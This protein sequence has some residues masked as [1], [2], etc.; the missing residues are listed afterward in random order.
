MHLKNIMAFHRKYSAAIKHTAKAKFP[1]DFRRSSEYNYI[2]N[3]NSGDKMKISLLFCSVLICMVFVSADNLAINGDLNTGKTLPD[4]WVVSYDTN[5]VRY[6]QEGGRN[7][8]PAVAITAPNDKA[9]LRQYE[10]QLVAGVRY[11]LSAWIRTENFS[12][13]Q[14]GSVAV[15]L[16]DYPW[17]A[18]DGFRIKDN[19]SDWTYYEKEIIAPS[20]ANGKYIILFYAGKMTGSVWIDD[21]NLE[22]LD[23]D[24]RTKSVNLI[25]A[26]IE[27]KKKQTYI[28]PQQSSDFTIEIKKEPGMDVVLEF[29]AMLAS[30]Y[31]SGY[32]NALEL[33]VNGNACSPE[34]VLGRPKKVNFVS[35]KGERS[36]LE[37]GCLLVFYSPEMD[38]AMPTNYAYYPVPAF[39]IYTY[40]IRVTALAENGR[41]IITVKNMLNPRYDFELVLDP[42][43]YTCVPKIKKT[44]AFMQNKNKTKIIDNTKVFSIAGKKTLSV[45]Y[46][47]FDFITDDYLGG[48]DS[49][50]NAEQIQFNNTNNGQILNVWSEKHPELTFRKEAALLKDG[51][52]LSLKAEWT[53]YTKAAESPREYSFRVPLVLLKGAKYKAAFGR[54]YSI[55]FTEGVISQ[56]MADGELANS[57]FRFINFKSDNVSLNMDFCPYGITHMWVDYPNA[58]EPT[59]C[60]IKKSG[61]Y[62]VFTPLYT[63]SWAGKSFLGEFHSAKLLIYEG[64]WDYH[65]KHSHKSWNYHSGPPAD[66]VYTF[67]TR[68]AGFYKK[69][70]L[71][72]Y[73]SEKGYG[74][75]STRGMALSSIHEKNIYSNAV[76][77]SAGN[78][79][80]FIIDIQ[81]GIY[82][83]TLNLGSPEKACGPFS[84]FIN[85]EKAADEIT[86]RAGEQKI[87]T[88]SRY[89]RKPDN[90]IVVRFT[91]K[92]WAVK[93][94]ARQIYIQQNEDYRIDRN[95]FVEEGIFNPDWG[96]RTKPQFNA[97]ALLS[98]P[99]YDSRKLDWRGDMKMTS[100]NS[101]AHSATEF[102]CNTPEQVERRVLELKKQGY[103][104]INYGV[105]FWNLAYRHRLSDAMLITRLITETAH[106]HNMKV[107]WHA[108]MPVIP[109]QGT[110]MQFMLSH[111]DWLKKDLRTGVPTLV[112]C[113]FNSGFRDDLRTML[114]TFTRETGVDGLMLDECY[115][116]DLDY[117]GCDNCRARFKRDTGL[118]MPYDNA[119]EIYGNENDSTWTA[120]T[121]WAQKS[122]G[123]WW[124]E[125]AGDLKKVN[126][127][128]VLMSYSVEHAE[129]NYARRVGSEMIEMARGANFIGTEQMPNNTIELY[130]YLYLF[131]K[132]NSAI[133]YSFHDTLPW[134][135]VYHCNDPAFAY[136][137]WSMN[138]MNAQASWMLMIEG[139]NPQR[140]QDL[141]YRVNPVDTRPVAD[142]GI[143]FSVNT[144][145]FGQR[146][147]KG[148]PD[149]GGWSQILTDF[150]IMH[151]FILERDLDSKKLAGYKLVV[152]P[153]V[154]CM[155]EAQARAIEKYVQTGGRLLVSGPASLYDESGFAHSNF[156]LGPLAGLRYSGKSISGPLQV[157]F[158]DGSGA[159]RYSSAAP[160][161]VLVPGARTEVLA[162][163]IAADGSAAGPAVTSTI[164]GSG[165]IIWCAAQPGAANFEDYKVAG[166]K[167]EFQKDEN[168]AEMM[169]K[170]VM[171]NM[172]DDMQ[173]KIHSAP[174]KLLINVLRQ[175]NKSGA[176]TLICLFNMTGSMN[177][178][179]GAIIPGKKEGNAFPAMNAD[180]TFDLR[181][182][183]VRKAYAVS[184]DYSGERPV[185]Y[186]SAGEGHLTITVDKKDIIAYTIIY[187]E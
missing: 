80:E 97:P 13:L 39:D 104:T 38:M 120:W 19:T 146:Q 111:L 178:K 158:R 150:H 62:L 20:S 49:W 36:T 55:N 148:I 23:E 22:C 163:F 73:D 121:R 164:A 185:R 31:F 166:Q 9:A 115:W 133:A 139:D 179:P 141:P 81:P 72:E 67:G 83:N 93:Y 136:A 32:N 145:D 33:M 134:G 59:M 6:D 40:R 99:V 155:N 5:A 66:T 107:V 63:A 24:A 71:S 159:F 51:L 16:T 34:D 29:K 75:S 103:N 135:L 90:K 60:R 144:R 157:K 43:S 94:I 84:V 101:A 167:W 172:Q 165:T 53:S 47:N 156:L 54:F 149:M 57:P 85:N 140:Y 98:V 174:D 1:I 147:F 45:Q 25:A 27:R 153:S 181:H 87:I 128:I 17:A 35:G 113:C 161:L 160:G 79:A 182:A 52:E 175:E 37:N 44:G 125:I 58:G 122:M 143:V 28:K 68:M 123:D 186:T 21:I 70:D 176:R 184:P 106:R 152:L 119:S 187:L 91:G 56:D 95:F 7:N 10:Y 30:T 114:T 86:T 137:G 151:E 109:N 138:N 102:M 77:G 88:V 18:G 41:N 116:H 173:F 100:W 170:L 108:D 8:T 82:V 76:C 180:V 112:L 162:D 92:T 26:R 74:W 65:E 110:G 118:E 64:E 14:G 130:R 2:N 89:I 169:K 46:R 15:Q 131:R 12:I 3:I 124:Q 154:N 4:H 177:L 126:P 96:F 11:R 42:F 61:E 171:I 105:C 168:L 69:T 117:C 48:L 78:A 129:L 127:N 142:I 50:S 132:V 183:P